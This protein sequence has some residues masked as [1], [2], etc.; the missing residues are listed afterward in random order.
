MSKLITALSKNKEVRIYM[1][2]TTELVEEARH[3]HDLSPVS[4]AAFGRM[5][6][7][8][9]MM[10]MM[11]KIEEEKITV[12]IRGNGEI[13]SMVA[14]ADI[15]GHVK[16]YLSNPLAE[17]HINAQGKLDV[18]GAV[19]QTGEL[20]VI[21]DIGLKEPFVGRS[22]LVSGEI[23]EDFAQYFAVSEQTPSAVG[24]GVLLD[25]KG[26]VKHAGGFIVQLLPDATD[27]TISQ[28][29]SNLKDVKSVTEFFEQGLDVQMIAGQIL[30][31]LGLD[32]MEQYDLSYKCDCSKEKMYT[33]LK[34]I[35]K[36]ELNTLLMEDGQAELSCHF[37]NSKYMFE[38]EELKAMI[39]SFED[40]L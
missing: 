13:R 7:G 28:L 39:D 25:P 20:I 5:L 24:L 26:F 19:G 35:G 16:G 12:Q 15:H 10:G 1:A 3:L 36:S 21:R 9:V 38:G 11:S 33:A 34:S 40:V 31:G 8:T 2:N 4:C 17:T 37:C 14:V 23:A 32:E 30:A 18:G 29:E 27:E 6:T 22:E